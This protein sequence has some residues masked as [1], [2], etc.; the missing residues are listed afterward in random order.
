[1]ETECTKTSQIGKKA[2]FREEEQRDSE[3][4]E[5]EGINEKELCDDHKLDDTDTFA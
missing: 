5:C 2:A 3:T 1:L 4:E